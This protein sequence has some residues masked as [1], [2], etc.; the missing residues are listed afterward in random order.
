MKY[1]ALWK[2]YSVPTTTQLSETH[3]QHK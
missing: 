1:V 2:V 3:S